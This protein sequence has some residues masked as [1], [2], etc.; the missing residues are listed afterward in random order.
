[1]MTQITTTEDLSM[2]LSKYRYASVVSAQKQLDPEARFVMVSRFDEIYLLHQLFGGYVWVGVQ[3][4]EAWVRDND[5][6]FAS[7]ELALAC[8]MSR[9]YMALYY[10]DDGVER[11]RWMADQLA[12]LKGAADPVVQ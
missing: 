7:L 8:A 9:K 3:C 6:P 4:D 10:S 1:M 2:C 5:H 11:L 12:E